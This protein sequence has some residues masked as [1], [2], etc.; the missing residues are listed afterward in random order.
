MSWFFRFQR[1][2][3]VVLFVAVGLTGAGV[4]RAE[5]SKKAQCAAAYEKSQELRAAG[6]LKAA[7]ENL[8]VCAQNFCPAF[9]QTDCAQWLTEVQRELPTIVFVAK[10]KAGEDTS[11]VAVSMDG[12]ELMKQLDGKAIII[13]P[14]PHTFRFELEGAEPMEQQV[15]I[16]QGQKDRVIAVSFAPAGADVPGDSPYA[17]AKGA[18]PADAG[19]KTN[20][21]GPLRPYAYIA[22]GVGAAGII[23]FAVLGAIGKSAENDLRNQGCAPNCSKDE[24]DAIKTKYIVADVLLGV[25]I[26]GIGTGVALFFL[27]Q[28]KNSEPKDTARGLKFDVRGAPGAA[29]AT[30]D[31]RF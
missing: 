5:D 31:G 17:A 10:D 11:A 26:A 15:V 16:R 19:E 9:V 12:A 1:V 22:G 20:G 13:D 25:G 2:A 8:V 27:S 30:I 24:T 7:N 23:G 14:G 3:L 21:P 18:A 29:Y 6:S 4:S 28:P